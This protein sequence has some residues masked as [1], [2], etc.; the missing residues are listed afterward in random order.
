MSPE[1]G[2]TY[3][4]R[5]E[6]RAPAERETSMLNALPG[7]VRHA[8]DNAPWFAERLAGI[9]PDQ[10]T[11]RAALARLPLLRKAELVELQPP[12]GCPSAA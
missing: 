5:Q 7:L 6:V 11:S 9:E 3:Y 1:E 2:G 4:D 10:V 8:I 12:T